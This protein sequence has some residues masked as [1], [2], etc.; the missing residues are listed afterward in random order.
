MLRSRSVLPK[1][2]VAEPSPLVALDSGD[3]AALTYDQLI[4]RLQLL[5]DQNNR[6]RDIEAGRIQTLQQLSAAEGKATNELTNSILAKQRSTAEAKRLSDIETT[7]ANIGAAVRLGLL[8][9]A[10]TIIGDTDANFLR[11]RLAAGATGTLQGGSRFQT[12]GSPLTLP[13]A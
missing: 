4:E 8:T 12:L 2:S 13:A 1:P 5:N 9:A 10:D 7:L 3:A 11:G 6:G